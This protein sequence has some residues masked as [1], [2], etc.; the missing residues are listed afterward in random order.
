MRF[1]NESGAA[2]P[3]GYLEGVLGL[4]PVQSHRLQR[5]R[6]ARPKRRLIPLKR[7]VNDR[8]LHPP[9]A[10]SMPADR[11]C[12]ER[13]ETPQWVISMCMVCLVGG[14]Y[15]GT[16]TIQVS[17]AGV[18]VGDTITRLDV[19]KSRHKIRLDG[20]DAPRAV[21]TVRASTEAAP[22]RAAGRP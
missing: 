4:Y 19:N 2:A 9:V 5:Q 16:H 12:V 10:H 7:R 15:A 3:N 14:T 1:A 17:I 6:A 22:S 13:W 21:A 20:V 18:H 11:G 8:S